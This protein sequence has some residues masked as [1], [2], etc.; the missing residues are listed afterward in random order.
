MIHLSGLKLKDNNN[1]DGDIEIKI[2]GLRPG[3]K[4][5]EE[6]LI[7]N[8]PES[9]MHPKIFRAHEDFLDWEVLQSNL[10]TLK[11]FISDNDSKKIINLLENIIS[12][13][14]PSYEI[15]DLFKNQ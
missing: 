11:K 7:G 2:T 14:K 13:Y 4:L 8:N 12:G 3:E 15:K 1:K 9:T 6:L 5:F 10:I